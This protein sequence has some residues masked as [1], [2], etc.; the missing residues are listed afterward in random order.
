MGIW[1]S[2][3]K[4][5]LMPCLL[6]RQRQRPKLGRF[7]LKKGEISIKTN[8]IITIQDILAMP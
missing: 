8:F 3:S 1:F 4:E 7:V 6:Y 2:P 5:K